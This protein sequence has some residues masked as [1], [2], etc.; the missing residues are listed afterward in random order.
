MVSYMRNGEEKEN[1]ISEHDSPMHKFI[2]EAF[3]LMNF[4]LFL[5]SKTYLQR[6]TKKLKDIESLNK[7]DK[8]FK[9]VLKIRKVQF[10]FS[11]SCR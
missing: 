6:W 8:S 10:K 11:I 2:I 7:A 1:I 9:I 3:I 5:N 4:G